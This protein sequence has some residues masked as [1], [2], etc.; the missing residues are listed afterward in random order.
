M[1]TLDFTYDPTFMYHELWKARRLSALLRIVYA[2]QL[3][4]LANDDPLC[5]WDGP[6]LP[7]DTPDYEYT[8]VHGT[9]RGYQHHRRYNI[10][11]CEACRDAHNTV[12]RASKARYRAKRRMLETVT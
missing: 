6:L 3:A 7:M 12:T 4:P 11:I 1:T 5:Q 9:E 8:L 2:R 10:E